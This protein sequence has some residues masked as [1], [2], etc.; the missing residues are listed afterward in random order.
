M[1]EV[2]I[3]N[4]VLKHLK[5]NNV[6]QAAII[7]QKNPCFYSKDVNLLN[8]AGLCCYQIGDFNGAKKY[9]MMSLKINDSDNLASG[10]LNYIHSQEFREFLVQYNNGISYIQ[11][12][13]YLKAAEVFEQI[14]QSQPDLIEPY[15]IVGLCHYAV[16][17]YSK[18][19]KY[20]KKGLALDTGNPHLIH[21]TNVVEKKKSKKKIYF[22]Q[23]AVFFQIILFIL[24]L[25][26]IYSTMDSNIVLDTSVVQNSNL[27]QETVKP[28][29][30][31]AQEII[32]D[33]DIGKQEKLFITD[34][35]E[36][37][38]TALKLFR[39][40][41]YADASEKF[42]I[43]TLCGVEKNI[44]AESLFFLA[45][46][47]EKLGNLENAFAFYKEYI[48]KYS[49]YNYYDDALYNYGLLLYRSNHQQE[50][51]EILQ[52]LADTQKDSMFFNSKVKFILEN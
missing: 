19:Y 50:A 14:I 23:Y 35:T 9:W 24:M 27:Q 52:I 47:H 40:G 16:K 2:F 31:V 26:K 18:A 48:E 21:Y 29:E 44:V 8:L 45:V 34:E 46:C 41:Q 17:R 22:Y 49:G 28:K 20:W 42:K 38:Q 4:E 37:F 33:T 30:E 25:I 7:L 15:I 10:Y 51:K 13:N 3:Y 43:I 5:Q 39:A 6:T 32:D 1:S 12:G 11:C 36:T